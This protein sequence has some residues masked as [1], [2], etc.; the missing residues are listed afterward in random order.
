MNAIAH[1]EHHITAEEI[2][3]TV[4][5]SSKSLNL[6]TVYR[7][8]DLLVEVGLISRTDLGNGRIMYASD[9]HGPHLHLTCRQCGVTIDADS[10]L[11]ASLSE[12]LQTRYGF[13]ADLKHL[14]VHGL[15]KSCQSHR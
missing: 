6:A 5:A 4:Q 12:Q 11:V 14:C 3:T 7:T 1:V 15:C 10:S 9:R 2:Y 8:L 13:K